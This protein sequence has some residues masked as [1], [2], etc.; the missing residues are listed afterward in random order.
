[1]IIET[2]PTIMGEQFY[3]GGIPLAPDQV[4]VNG[5]TIQRMFYQFAI[6]DDRTYDAELKDYLKYYANAPCWHIPAHPDYDE[7]SLNW[8]F[9]FLMDCGLDPF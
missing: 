4:S 3:P 2:M 9:D 1:M 6:R 5:K 8:M 7:M